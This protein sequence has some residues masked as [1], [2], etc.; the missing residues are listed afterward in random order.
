M[1]RDWGPWSWNPTLGL[2]V[3]FRID[4][5]RESSSSGSSKL[6]YKI[7]FQPSYK[8]LS[9]LVHS[10]WDLTLGPK[11]ESQLSVTKTLKVLS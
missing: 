9:I 7:T 11:I 4:G 6:K 1:R 2:D 10:G 3:T 5:W 8:L